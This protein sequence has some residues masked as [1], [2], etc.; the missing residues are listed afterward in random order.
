MRLPLHRRHR[1]VVVPVLAAVAA[2]ACRGGGSGGAATT[3]AATPAPAPT[4]AA[5]ADADTGAF[6]ISIPQSV[7]EFA[8]GKRTDYEQRDLGTLVRYEAPDGL[9][10]DVYVYPADPKLA[11]CGAACGDSAVKEEAAGFISLIP[12]YLSRGYFEK[13][14]VVENRALPVPAGAAWVSGRQVVMSVV[15][16]RMAQRSEYYLF[17]LPY[18]R[19]K[20]R[21]TY[22]DT[23]EARD[24]IARFASEVAR[25]MPSSRR[26][27]R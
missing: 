2:L 17:L 23:P 13:A 11:P 26:A 20:V 19:I 10:A 18:Y 15:R 16:D 9:Y 12:E 27:G 1:A 21:A 25:V 22:A 24:R 6:T 7:G 4:P 8:F 5:R 3:P 14:E